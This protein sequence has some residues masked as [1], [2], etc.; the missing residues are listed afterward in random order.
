MYSTILAALLALSSTQRVSALPARRAITD[1][2]VLNFALTLEHL[3]ATF[4]K[5]SLAKFSEADFSAAGYPD[6]TRG[7]FVQIQ[8]HESTHVD[9]LTTALETAGA[10]AVQACEYD[11][12]VT[13]VHSFVNLARVLEEVG[14]NAYTGGA[15][16]IDNKDY[17]TAAASILAVEA[18][19]EAWISS[20]V[21]KASAWDTAFETPLLPNAVYSLA[22]PFIK[23]CPAANVNS[24]PAL[25]PYP[26]L[27]FADANPRAGHTASLTF[28]APKD[29]SPLFVAFVSGPGAP[30]FV[31]IH[32]GNQVAIPKDLR[33]FVFC[34]VT[35]DGTK[36]DDSTTV[37]GPA[38]LNVEFDSRGNV[39]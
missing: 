33:G 35:N 32:D 14:T 4:Y 38:I 31:P 39:V 1:P 9:F 17:L 23:S 29:S 20:A 6:W 8:Q 30:T 22:A 15:Q 26:A 27:G 10:P 7:R 37:A 25:K 12:P 11:F 2:E 3:E 13:D 19:H 24:L 5:D 34:F 16:L 18:R 36:L 28:T 21:F